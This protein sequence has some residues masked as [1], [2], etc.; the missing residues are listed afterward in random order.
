L[1]VALYSYGHTRY[2]AKAGWVRKDLDLTNDLDAL[3]QKLNGL[4][5]NGGEEYVTRVCRDALNQQPWNA[6]KDALRLIFVCGNEPANQDPLVSLKEA[7]D[8]AGQK[9]VVINTIFCGPANHPEAQTWKQLAALAQGRFGS[10][11]QD[12]GTVAIATPMDKELAE[13]SEKL[14]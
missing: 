11:D 2:D 3:Y 12:R 5:T 14:N 4:T 13:L 7:A 8:L 1:R 10:I 6:D 9:G